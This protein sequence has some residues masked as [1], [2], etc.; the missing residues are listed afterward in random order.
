MSDQPGSAG[1]P[2]LDAAGRAR[3]VDVSGKDVTVRQAT[4]EGLV[5]C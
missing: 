1:F 3:M 2:H 4:A 5:R